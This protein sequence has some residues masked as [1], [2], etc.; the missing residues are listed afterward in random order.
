MDWE[1]FFRD[2]GSGVTFSIG[3]TP[4]RFVSFLLTEELVKAV[5]ARD[6]IIFE[7]L[8]TVT[9]QWFP[10]FFANGYLKWIEVAGSW[11]NGETDEDKFRFIMREVIECDRL[12]IPEYK[13]A[14]RK[15][16]EELDNR[17]EL[18]EKEK[19]YIKLQKRRQKFNKNRD[20]LMI[21]LIRRDG[22]GCAVCGT[23]EDLT[24]DH[25]IAV[26]DG[27]SDDLE[28]LKILC[29]SHNSQKGARPV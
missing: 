25:I 19:A 7:I 21:A 10:I 15:W 24:V 23:V 11:P 13:D 17:I 12:I 26:V 5:E 27:G 2:K 29:R 22:D 20:K 18:S 9:K 1:K 28:N 6:P 8:D 3:E 4:D 16:L 14:A